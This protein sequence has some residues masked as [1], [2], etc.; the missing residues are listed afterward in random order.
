MIFDH[1]VDWPKIMQ[2]LK[3]GLL[4]NILKMWIPCGYPR[5]NPQGTRLMY[6][7]YVV[8][9]VSFAPS[10]EVSTSINTRPFVLLQPEVKKAMC[11]LNN[12]VLGKLGKEFQK[13]L[14]W[15]DINEYQVTIFA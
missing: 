9:S 12:T 10:V 11:N 6:Q 13:Q 1:K 7:N 2:L 14:K 4:P 3:I 5:M 15:P 8:C